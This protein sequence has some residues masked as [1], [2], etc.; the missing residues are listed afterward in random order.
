[1]PPVAA[2]SPSQARGNGLRAIAAACDQ[3]STLVQAIKS[4]AGIIK[5]SRP[6]TAISEEAGGFPLSH[7]PVDWCV[8]LFSSLL[9]RPRSARSGRGFFIGAL[10]AILSAAEGPSRSR[11]G[12]SVLPKTRFCGF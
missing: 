4:L 5:R 10:P 7:P 1:M 11:A 9:P 6:T 8:R 2:A 12:N 3:A